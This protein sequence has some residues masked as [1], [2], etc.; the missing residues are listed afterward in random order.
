MSVQCFESVLYMAQLGVITTEQ[1]RELMNEPD[2]GERMATVIPP[3][4]KCNSVMRLS[5]ADDSALCRCGFTVDHEVI[6]GSR[7]QHDPAA[8][9]LAW[10]RETKPPRAEPGIRVS[11]QFS[12][13]DAVCWDRRGEDWK[14]AGLHDVAVLTGD[15]HGLAHQP[16]NHR[17]IGLAVARGSERVE[18]RRSVMYG[19][20]PRGDE[21]EAAKRMVAAIANKHGRGRWFSM[22]DAVHVIADDGLARVADVGGV[23]HVFLRAVYFHDPE[24][25]HETAEGA[26]PPALASWR[27]PL[28]QG[29][30]QMWLKAQ[31]EDTSA[32]AEFRYKSTWSNVPVDPLDVTYDGWAL[33]DLLEVS[34]AI[35]Q[36][37]AVDPRL[38]HPLPIP[39]TSLQRG[40]VSAYQSAELRKRVEAPKQKDRNQVTMENDE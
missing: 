14:V 3:C 38:T 5:Y 28:S 15:Q 33:R 1:A 24:Q 6:L 37:R 2:Q 20:A 25:T 9:M 36:E 12:E 18:I 27:T 35:A 26:P 11:E 40:A 21:R 17:G 19:V 8:Y 13:L 7:G 10:G 34:A 29:G 4:P 32:D 31:S 23:P 39:M 30:R 16:G 22:L